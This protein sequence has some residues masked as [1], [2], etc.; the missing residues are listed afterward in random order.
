MGMARRSFARIA[1]R[2]RSQIE[3]KAMTFYICNPSKNTECMKNDCL[4]YMSGNCFSTRNE[5]FS[6]CDRNGEPISYDE[7]QYD[8]MQKYFVNAFRRAVF[9][10]FEHDLI[11]GREAE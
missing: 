6:M 2:A 9:K 3:V 4:Y 10:T 8:S 5:A 7:T 11:Y 1:G